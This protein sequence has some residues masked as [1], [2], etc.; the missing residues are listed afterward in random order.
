MKKDK[1]YVR[2]WLLRKRKQEL[3]KY[4]VSLSAPGGE[5]T[6][7]AHGIHLVSNGVLTNFRKY[8]HL[9]AFIFTC[10]SS[11]VSLSCIL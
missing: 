10:L 8:P 1:I 3:K 9:N 4:S 5:T 2:F 7:V 6:P 11:F